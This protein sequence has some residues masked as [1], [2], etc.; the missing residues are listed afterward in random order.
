MKASSSA[1][2]QI[3]EVEARLEKKILAAVQSKDQDASMEPPVVDERVSRLEAQMQQMATHQQQVD[4]RL[5][6][7]QQQ[8]DT[9]GQQFNNALDSKLN[10]QMSRIE[11]LLTKRSRHE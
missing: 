5:G 7:M 1:T 11:A 6:Q 9:Q 8:I 2:A 3:A 10:E 4:S